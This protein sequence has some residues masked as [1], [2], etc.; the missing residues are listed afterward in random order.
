[1]KIV[2]GN[3]S[4]RSLSLIFLVILTVLSSQII[5]SIVQ[6]ENLPQT[7]QSISTG[8]WPPHENLSHM[9]V[10]DG[11]DLFRVFG[12]KSYPAKNRAKKV[13]H[14]IRQLA[15]DPSFDPDTIEIKEKNGFHTIYADDLKII[16]IHS[17]DVLLEGNFSQEYFAKKIVRKNIVKAINNYRYER[18]PETLKK[19]ALN[20]LIRTT[21]LFITL[22]LLFWSFKKSGKLLEQ[23]FKRKI[24]QLE[25]KSKRILQAQQ[26]W[27]M[28]KFIFRLSRVLLVLIVVYIFFHFVLGLFPWTRFLALTSLSYVANPVRILWQSFI[29]YLPNLIFLIIIYYLFRYLLRFTKAFFNQVDHSQLKISGFD[30]EWA[31]PTYRIARIF[32]IIL[33]VVIAYPYIPGSGSD[34]FKGISILVGVLFSLGSSSL[35][36][37]I[38]AG[39]T[40]I[41]R[42]AFKVGDKVKFGEYIGDVIDVR[43]ME[44]HIRS[45]KNE[46]IVIPNS[47]ILSDE[48]TNY[49]SM[50]TKQ[51]LILHTTVGIGY[52]VPWRQ[53]EAMLLMAAERTSG[54]QR[55]SEPFVLQKALGD[56]GVTYELN[57]F[58]RNADKMVQIY[59][60]LHSNIQDVFNEYKVAIMTPHYVGDTEKP[61]I[62]PKEEWYVS[63]AHPPSE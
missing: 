5:H 36:A 37:N 51:G 45:P 1:M 40:M 44:T 60:D 31:L 52:E 14:R 20:A 23:R 56:F 28:L 32:V 33:G 39:Y 46:E 19:N 57:V 6:A 10:V 8:K 35:I 48:I 12:I 15:K 49:S 47:K 63:P 59:S 54:S 3:Y 43:L 26:I 34:A 53:V 11:K 58:C 13:E 9:V 16:R 24:E 21:A 42:R 41:Y 29:D 55:K 62:V 27:N 17:E 22:F 2:K 7:Q 30:A 61:K 50:S 18:L 4:T 25:S 38:V